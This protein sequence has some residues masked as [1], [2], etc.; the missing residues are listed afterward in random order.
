MTIEVP[1]PVPAPESALSQSQ[2]A[3]AYALSRRSSLLATGGLLFT[4]AV[5]G[6]TFLVVKDAIASVP[7][8][9]F[10]GLRFAVACA[11]MLAVRPK[12]LAGLGRGGWRH[13]VL[14]GLVLAAGYA[15][16]TFGLQTASA[17]V[18]G[19]VTGLFVVFTPLIAAVVLRRRVPSA[20]WA[21][22][23]LATVGLG[24]ISLHGLSIGRGE[25]L[26]VVGAFFFAVH[27]VGL[28]EWSHRNDAYALAVVQ[29]GTVAAVSLLLAVA[30]NGL[31][32]GYGH[33]HGHGHGNGLGHHL[34][35]LPSSAAG[36]ASIAVTALL[37]TAA[38]FFLQTW[39]Q[40][41]MPATRA[42]V[43]LTMEPV[44][45]GVTGVLAG[46]TLA[47]RGWIGAALVLAAMYSVEL[48]GRR[49]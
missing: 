27:I 40:A 43:V 20:V 15:A 38:G 23:V 32:L 22:V 3:D 49:R 9:D 6:T 31:G 25:L 10:L 24:L 14:L 1:A 47:V 28:G 11:A 42:A 13:G 12:T 41:R 16:Q 4:T 36:W 35:T 8:L 37:G 18:S 21:A 26:T 39:S 19:F 46:E 7:V 44:F 5:W 33:G 48:G 34:L 17:S 29:I 30:G 2:Y 45:A